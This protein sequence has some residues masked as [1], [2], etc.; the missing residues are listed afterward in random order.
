MVELVIA[1]LLILCNGLFALSELAIVSA[2]KARL[3]AMAAQGNKGAAAALQLSE[4]PGKF[5]STVQIG[6]TLIGV[7]AGAF[8]GAALGGM[9][10]STLETWGVHDWAAEP[11][12]FGIVISLITY[13]SVVIGELV[14]KQ[15]A[16]RHTETI[17]AALAPTM[18]MLSQIGAPAVW[19]LD[20][21]TRLIFALLGQRASNES[22]VTEEEIKHLVAEAEAA[23]VIEND[24]RRM[25]GGILRLSDRRVRALMT[26][27]TEVD[28]INLAD[29]DEDIRDTIMKSTH[30]RRPRT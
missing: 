6:I 12:G 9:L 23:G 10:T 19:L 26:P 3:R 11:L 14:P 5:L 1:A 18:K 8:S 22:A 30:S 25:I 28:W 29:S 13:F 7:L 21:S 4:D 15:F 27:R 16:L 2:R 20:S 17:A 24:E